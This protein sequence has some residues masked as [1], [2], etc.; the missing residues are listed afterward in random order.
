MSVL[1]ANKK[2]VINI[3]QEIKNGDFKP[4]VDWGS[5]NKT[6][7]VPYTKTCMVFGKPRLYERIFKKKSR[8]RIGPNDYISVIIDGVTYLY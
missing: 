4:I 5:K 3:K 1:S 7:F 6:E 2:G 8:V